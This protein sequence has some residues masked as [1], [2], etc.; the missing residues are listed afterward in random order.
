MQGIRDYYVKWNK[1]D[2]ER[3]IVHD[4]TQIGSKKVEF[5]QVESRVVVLPGPGEE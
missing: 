3:Q 2:A 5:I 4:L 1:S